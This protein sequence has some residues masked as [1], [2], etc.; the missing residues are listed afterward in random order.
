MKNLRYLS[1]S[2][3][4]LY[5]KIEGKVEI[6]KL[7]IS[8]IIKPYEIIFMNRKKEILDRYSY[9]EIEKW[10]NSGEEF[11]VMATE[12]GISH[13]FQSYDTKRINHIISSYSEMN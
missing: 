2:F 13:F 11:F 1:H 12:D 7:I 3:E 4:V 9:I 5:I 8:L 6:L 10:G